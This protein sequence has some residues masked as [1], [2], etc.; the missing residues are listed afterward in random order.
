MNG[1]NISRRQRGSRETHAMQQHNP[2]SKKANAQC[3]IQFKCYFCKRLRLEFA[4][5]S[6][7][8]LGH[9]PQYYKSSLQYIKRTRL[10]FLALGVL[11]FIP[12]M[13]GWGD[14]V[15]SYHLKKVVIDAG[16]GGHDP[17]ALGKRYQEKEIALGVALKLGKY[18]HENFPDVEVIYTRKDDTFIP[19]Y[20]RAD[21]ANRNKADLFISIHANSSPTSHEYSGTETWVM[22]LHKDDRNFEV[23][24]KENEVIVLEKDYN[25][26][27]EGF[28]PNSA[29]SY[30]TFSL[31][32]NAY[33]DQ[34]LKFAALVQEEL[35][36]RGKR[37][38][39]GVKQAGFLV[40]WK[41]TMPSV[42]VETGYISSTLEEKYLH[43]DEGQD[44]LASSIFR[45][46]REYKESVESR[47]QLRTND[48]FKKSD[49]AIEPTLVNEDKLVYKVQITAAKKKLE[50]N[51]EFFSKL[52]EN[53]PDQM[54][55]EKE[56]DGIYKYVIGNDST[57]QGILDFAQ[58][59]KQ[60]YPGSFIVAM[61]G[62]KLIPLK[63]ALNSNK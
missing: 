19:L 52:K 20:E 36:E 63:E 45:A 15:S 31:M 37:I 60:Y 53:F 61:K 23:A 54:M 4:K 32:Q 50:T 5:L 29:E 43:S 24:K 27:Y 62:R 55:E 11:F 58:K 47:S 2:K 57:Y 10:R 30:I 35:R 6:K 44:L 59:V 38:D 8:Y 9:M 25:T 12:V 39:R 34:S 51:A 16:H 40:L 17:G 46:F 13:L 42:L 1:F 7:K 3:Q 33:L 18:I 49:T 48:E 21:I 28:D 26:H 56:V 14:K 22:G 41:T